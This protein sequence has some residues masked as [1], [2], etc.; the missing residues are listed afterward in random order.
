VLSPR[1]HGRRERQTIRP[2]ATRAK[3]IVHLLKDGMNRSTL[4]SQLENDPEGHLAPGSYLLVHALLS[5]EAPRLRKIL[6]LKVNALVNESKHEVVSLFSGA[7]DVSIA[8]HLV[9]NC[10]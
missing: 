3:G 6:I 4:C 2:I 8:M 9:K 5:G 7:R 1:H 10:P